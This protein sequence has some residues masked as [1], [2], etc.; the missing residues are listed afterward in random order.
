[1]VTEAEVLKFIKEKPAILKKITNLI[2][3]RKDMVKP[4][5]INSSYY[6]NDNKLMIIVH[7]VEKYEKDSGTGASRVVATN[8]GNRKVFNFDEILQMN[9]NLY[10]TKK[11][12]ALIGTVKED[13][14]IEQIPL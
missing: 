4:I 10:R 13:G 6:K 8:G 7:N 3:I 5:S 12:I 2:F 14:T 11:D 9:F 1:M